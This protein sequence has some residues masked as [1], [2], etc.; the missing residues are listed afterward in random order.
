MLYKACVFGNPVSQ[1]KSPFI[2]EE[3]AKQFDIKFA[4]SKASPEIEAFTSAANEFLADPDVL[5]A[6]ITVPFKEQAYQYVDELS[7]H[8]QRAGAVN[9]F[10]KRDERIIGD[11]TDGIGLIQDLLRNKVKLKGARVLLIGA[12]GAAKGALPALIDAQVASVHIYNRTVERARDLLL[13]LSEDG[14]CQL[15]VYEDEENF[16]LIINATSLSLQEK[17]PSLPDFIYGESVVCYDMVYLNKPT[18]F[19]RHAKKAGCKV[20]IDGLGMLVGQAA[21]SFYLWFGKMPDVEP[22]LV[23]LRKALQAQ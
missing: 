4:Y 3:F 19:L 12:G 15:S 21:Q 22:V 13:N 23:K 11:N 16:D 2:H 5:G 6:N 1:S 9:T 18:S 7:P 20:C 14:D 8:A 17:V 10:V